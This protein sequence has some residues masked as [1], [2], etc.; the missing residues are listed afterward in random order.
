MSDHSISPLYRVVL[1]KLRSAFGEPSRVVGR[2]C[3]WALRRLA[4]LSALN[5]LL[6]GGNDFPVL[7]VFDPHDLKNG[8]SHE[9]IRA[10]E[11]IDPLITKVQDRIA[12]A[13]QTAA[14][15]S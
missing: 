14:A 2:D 5:I 4:Y 15:V 12:R 10:E 7:W 8:V 13:G 9:A 3:H 11:E 1:N 6:D